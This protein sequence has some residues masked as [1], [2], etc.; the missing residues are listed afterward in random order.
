TV[1]LN[2]GL[3]FDNKFENNLFLSYGSFNTLDARYRLEASTDKVTVQFSIARNSSDNDYDYQL[4][5]GENLNGQ[6]H[7][8]AL[9]AAIGIRLNATNQLNFYSEYYSA[10]RHFSL[11]WPNANR[12]KYKNLNLRNLLEW[13]SEFGKFSSSLQAAFLSEN[14]EYYPDIRYDDHSYGQAET[15]IGKYDLSYEHS[16][17]MFIDVILCHPH[18]NF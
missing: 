9:N 15:L 12:T 11:V 7:N 14:Y 6:F 13:E 8:T 1:H 17:S 2:T 4:R 18:N 10:L 3:T 16:N 5:E